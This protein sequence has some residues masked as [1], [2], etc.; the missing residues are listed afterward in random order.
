[1][2][3]DVD[4]STTGR[5][6]RGPMPVRLTRLEPYDVDRSALIDFLTRNS[7]PFHAH[8]RPTVTDIEQRIAAGT[9]R[10]EDND[11][12]WI[13][14][15][16]LGRVGIF[17][18][19]DLQDGNPMFD[20]RLS[21]R[22]RGRG[23]GEQ[24]LK[25][26]TDLLFSTMP[27]ANRFEGQTRADNVAMR[28][29]FVNCGWLKEAHYREAWPIGGGEHVATVGYSILR[30]DWDNEQLTTF[31]WNDL[32]TPE[33]RSDAVTPTVSAKKPWQAIKSKPDPK[34][35]EQILATLPEWFGQPES[36][37]EYIEAATTMETWTV[38]TEAGTVIGVTLINHHFAEAAEIH[39]TAVT[40]THHGQGVGTSMISAIE[41][42]LRQRGVLMLTVKT[43][44]SSHPDPGYARTRQFYRKHGF[45]PLEETTLWGEGTPCLV[46]VKSLV[47]ESANP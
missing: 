36:N 21:S 44:G 11:S 8:S 43:L 24:A 4:L 42:D 35:V 6:Y 47:A 3:D 30:R 15:H 31:D 17:R 7:F 41:A 14:H 5:Q 38:R 27:H 9:F 32:Q 18:F 28:K 1:M 13:E 20:L 46:M 33:N 26:A 34:A 25:A 37:A 10:D 39:F 23:L 19:E 29:I 2:S 12:Y 16:D 40:K 22:F 45:I